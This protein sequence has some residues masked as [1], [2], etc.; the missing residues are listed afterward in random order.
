VDYTKVIFLARYGFGI[1]SDNQEI[2]RLNHLIYMDIKLYVAT[3]NELKEL[4]QLTG[5][6]SRDIKMVFGIEK[7][8]TLSIAK[9][10][11]KMR[12]F[13]TDDDDDTMEAMNKD[14]IYRF[15]GHMQSKQIKHA[16]MKQ[17]L[18]KEHLHR[19]KSILKIKLNRK[20]TIKAINTYATPV[21]TF[22]FGIVKWTPTD[23]ENLQTKTTAL[24]TRYRFQHPRAA[25][26]R[27]TLPHQM[28]G[29][30]LIHITR[31]HGKQVR[32]LQTYFL[33]KQVTSPLHAA[34]VKADDRY[35]PLDLVRANENELATDEEYN[36]IKRQWSQKPYTADIRMI[37]AN[38]M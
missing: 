8:K 1:H 10:K 32:L 17:K 24:L 38:N 23:L 22:S 3:I 7:C 12:N 16:Q 26:E 6:F 19:I 9:G 27:L 5:T 14:E 20:I 18:G 28:G 29:R 11:L 36:N 4:L 13:I 31:L 2:H 33:N 15:L 21:L 34:I 25:K 30:G 37:S 35:T